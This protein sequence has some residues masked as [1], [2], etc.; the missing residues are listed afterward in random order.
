MVFNRASTGL[1]EDL[2]G[3]FDLLDDAEHFFET[4]SMLFEVRVRPVVEQ[5]PHSW[6]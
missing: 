3:L 2:R 4:E 1:V 6:H 5:V